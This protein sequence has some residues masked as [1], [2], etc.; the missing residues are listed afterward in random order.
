MAAFV[1]NKLEISIWSSYTYSLGSKRPTRNLLGGKTS[2]ASKNSRSFTRAVDV[3]ETAAVAQSVHGR[4]RGYID[5]WDQVANEVKE[6]TVNSAL[7]AATK[8]EVS[9][10][11]SY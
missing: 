2:E 4:K 3:F 1:A 7:A 9:C 5:W 6:K 8:S 11:L 10:A